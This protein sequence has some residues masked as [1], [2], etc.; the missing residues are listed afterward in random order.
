MDRHKAVLG[1]LVLRQGSLDAETG[2]GGAG[3]EA[4]RLLF[5]WKNSNFFFALS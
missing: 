5:R 4:R 1:G 2:G 3:I